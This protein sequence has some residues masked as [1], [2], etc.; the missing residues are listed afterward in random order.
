MAK[1]KVFTETAGRPL[2]NGD[3]NM[4]FLFPD[5]ISEARDRTGLVI[6]PIAP[7]EW[8]G[9][10]LTMGCDPLLAHHYAKRL[11]KE[12]KTPYYPP[13]YIGTERERSSEL[14][15][16]L[17]LNPKANIEGMDFPKNSVASAYYREE[18]FALVVRDTLDIFFSRMKFRKVLIVNGHGAVNQ[19][20]TLDRLCAEFNSGVK[21]GARVMWVYP[22]ISQSLIAGPSGM[23]Q[24]KKH[25]CLE[26]PGHSV[27]TFPDF[28][29]P[30]SL[31]AQTMQ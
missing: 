20:E 12:L 11:A 16:A 3:W 7:I 26:R 2:D 25:R 9:P 21:K 10:H 1:K 31:K 24:V 22:G 28:R 15:K 30:E 27:L 8:H 29:R 4:A 23:L 6:L 13:L 5:E 19:S 17:G 14:L 18:T